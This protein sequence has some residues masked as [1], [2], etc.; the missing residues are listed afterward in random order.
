MEGQIAGRGRA[1]GPPPSA[2]PVALPI[3]ERIEELFFRRRSVVWLLCLAPAVLYLLAIFALPLLEIALRSF[4][5][6]KVTAQHYVRIFTVPAY[7]KVLGVTFRISLSVALICLVLGYP[8][9]SVMANV[10]PR[11]AN[12]L[13]GLVLL[14][15]WTSV[16]VRTYGWMVLLQERG[17][18]NSLLRSVGVIESPLPLMYNRA[19]VIIGMVHVLLP[20]MTL[21]LYAVM[22]GIDPDLM[23]AARSLGGGSLRSFLRVYLPLTLPGVSAGFLLVFVSAVGFF[24]TPALLGGRGDVMIGNLI[25]T[26]INALINWGLG[27]ALA[28]FLLVVVLA[29]VFLY[30]WILPLERFRPAGEVPVTAEAPPSAPAGPRIVRPAIFSRPLSGGS[31]EAGSG[32]RAEA[33]GP[34]R[35]YGWILLKV[36]AGLVI[37]YLVLPI[38]IVIPMSFSSTKFL[39]FPPPGLSLQWYRHYFSSP[40]WTSATLLSFRVAVVVTILATVLGTLAALALVR[41]RFRGQGI[42]Q[43]LI[44][45]PMIVPTVVTAV[46]VYF[47]FVRLRL[48]GTMWSLVF[49]HAVLAIP[50][51]VLTVS[52]TLRGFDENLERVAMSLGSNQFWALARITIPLI[53]PAIISGALFAFIISFDEVVIAIFLAGTTSATLPKRMWDDVQMQLDPTIAAVSTLLIGIS[54]TILVITELLRLRWQRV[55]ARRLADLVGAGEATEPA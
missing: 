15:F 10:S 39:H 25:E 28:V 44:L 19:G 17:V 14:P 6:P 52:A 23:R 31:A 7:L 54:L 48:V 41:V 36:Y 55:E 20:F 40:T 21:P 30:Q 38:L 3:W 16:L 32:D 35:D 8:L 53:A 29:M 49:A 1:E 13:L 34:R 12:R 51:V 37:A 46:A 22:R 24:I 33:E 2:R 42:V 4:Y 47:L 5:I 43:G 50:F 9:A 26:Q 11:T 45:A 18:V 27:A